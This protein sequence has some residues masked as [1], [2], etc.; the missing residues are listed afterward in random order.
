[1][2]RQV[3]F[4]VETFFELEKCVDNGSFCLYY[5]VFMC[6]GGW[7]AQVLR[8][9]D[10]MGMDQKKESDDL[11]EHCREAIDDECMMKLWNNFA[12][13]LSYPNLWFLLLMMSFLVIFLCLSKRLFGMVEITNYKI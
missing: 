3:I 4:K 13:V 5:F 9:A 6:D 12:L 11:R 8:V 1:M 10:E 2:W 7:V